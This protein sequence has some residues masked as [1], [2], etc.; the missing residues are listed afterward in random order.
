MHAL[1]YPVGTQSR[2]HCGRCSHD[3]RLG[4]ERV[5][6]SETEA[7]IV[8]LKSEGLRLRAIGARLMAEGIQPPSGGAKWGPSTRRAAAS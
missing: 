4:R 5:I 8:E 3:D 7:L 2:E 6:S 1:V